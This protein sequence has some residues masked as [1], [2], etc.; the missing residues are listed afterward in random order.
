MSPPGVD[1]VLPQT[2]H[3]IWGYYDSDTAVYEGDFMW[4]DEEPGVEKN[5]FWVVTFY[6]NPAGVVAFMG[7]ATVVFRDVLS[8]AETCRREYSVSGARR[9]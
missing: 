4:H 5:E 8:Q 6:L 7:T 3:P 2:P 1:F 9:P